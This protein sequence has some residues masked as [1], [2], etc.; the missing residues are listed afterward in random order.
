M[1]LE[2]ARD[3]TERWR[4]DYSEFRPYSAAF[5]LTPAESARESGAEAA[6][7]STF[8]F[9]GLRFKDTAG[10]RYI[11]TKIMSMNRM[12]T[13]ERIS[14]HNPWKSCFRMLLGQ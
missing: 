11:Q 6:W 9:N 14:V 3:K 5:Y 2:D 10:P 7:A 12:H 8:S 4:R 1:S 13:L